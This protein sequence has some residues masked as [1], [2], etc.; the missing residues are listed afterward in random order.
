M[1]GGAR[2]LLMYVVFPLWV[3]AGFLD[4]T[5]H[6]RTRIE[7]T[8]GLKENLFHWLL[9]AEIGVAMLA[10]ALLEVNAA[11]LLLVLATFLA[12]ELTTWIE[13]RYTAPL[14][15]VTPTEQMIHS[16]LELLPLLSLALLAVQPWKP[17]F[18]LRLKREPWSSAYLWSAFAAAALFNGLPL[19]EESVRCWRGRASPR[20]RTPA[21]PAPT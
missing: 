13:L 11:I 19:V 9:M 14:R 3:A 21:P 20:P 6:R 7:S 18:G 8:S 16:F 2:L 12:H 5:R 17:D 15:E 1:E 4:W 10:V